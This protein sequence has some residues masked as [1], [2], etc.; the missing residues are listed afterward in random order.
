MAAGMAARALRASVPACRKLCD[1]VAFLGALVRLQAL[2][3]DGDPGMGVWRLLILPP[4]PR[5]SQCA[6]SPPVVGPMGTP[7]SPLMGLPRL[8]P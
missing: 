3:L 7:L 8:V 6:H 5:C 4:L 1:L 2:S